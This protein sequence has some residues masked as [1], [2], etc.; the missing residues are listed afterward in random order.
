VLSLALYNKALTS[1][2][3][4]NGMNTIA[5]NRFF[6][7][8][9]ILIYPVGIFGY[10]CT[11]I[12]IVWLIV[13]GDWKILA[14]G[15]VIATV[16]SFLL[17]FLLLPPGLILSELAKSTKLTNFSI[18]SAS[19]FGVFYVTLISWVLPLQIMKL[20]IS[21]ISEENTIPV[22]ILSYGVALVP[23]MRLTKTATEI[24]EGKS[25]IHF[26][27]NCRLSL[28]LSAIILGQ[29]LKLLL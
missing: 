7:F 16:V 3:N 27:F 19:L 2:I 1:I 8:L 25:L 6:K 15:L 22:L 23:F 9:M 24:E 12:A 26:S 5:P 28:L 11:P 13:L 20:F 29:G 10:V 21:K 17:P 14:L 18:N 4:S